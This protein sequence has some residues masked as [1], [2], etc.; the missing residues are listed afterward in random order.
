MRVSQS[1]PRLTGPRPWACFAYLPGVS[2]ERRK[3]IRQAAPKTGRAKH[4]VERQRD[5]VCE[6]YVC[7][8]YAC[9]PY[10]C[11]PYACEPYACE[12]YACEP[13]A[14]EPI[15]AAAHRSAVTDLFRLRALGS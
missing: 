4:T 6:P 10:A 7:E 12:P 5:K 13:Y 14:C 2:N 8:P 11:E 3:P 15:N 9:E 1:T